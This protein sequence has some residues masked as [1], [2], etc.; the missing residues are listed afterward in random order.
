VSSWYR[1]RLIPKAITG[2]PPEP[3]PSS[4]GIA[5]HDGVIFAG[6]V[7]PVDEVSP[8]EVIAQTS[9]LIEPFAPVEDSDEFI[10]PIVVDTSSF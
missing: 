3:A 6:S 8:G 9:R 1:L 5:N 7:D 10:P 2:H 4:F